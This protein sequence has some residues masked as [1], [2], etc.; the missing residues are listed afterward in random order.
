M[1]E[2]IEKIFSL[3]DAVRQDKGNKAKLFITSQKNPIEQTRKIINLIN[4]L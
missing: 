4:N 2:S 1:T 3:P